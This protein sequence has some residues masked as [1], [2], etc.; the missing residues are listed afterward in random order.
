MAKK[1]VNVSNDYIINQ[2]DD[3]YQQYEV[4]GAVSNNIP[5][6]LGIRGA[7][8]LRGQSTSQNYKTTLK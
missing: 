7:L 8:S 1:N 5:F 4:N 6:F 3:L 2:L